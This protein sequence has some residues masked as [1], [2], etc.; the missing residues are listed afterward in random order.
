MEDGWEEQMQVYAGRQGGRVDAQTPKTTVAAPPRHQAR[1]KS[2]CETVQRRRARSKGPPRR[3]G[4]TGMCSV[5]T[6]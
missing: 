3:A 4:K 1:S 5:P 6:A 2:L